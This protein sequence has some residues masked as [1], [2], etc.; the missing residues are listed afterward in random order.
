MILVLLSG[1][2]AQCVPPSPSLGLLQLEQRVV[3]FWTEESEVNAR[4]ADYSLDQGFTGSWGV[5]LPVPAQEDESLGIQVLGASS[6]AL[7]M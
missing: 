7:W 4:W 2:F 1:E 5:T 6:L 3:H